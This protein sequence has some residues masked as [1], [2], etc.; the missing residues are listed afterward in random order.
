MKTATLII[1]SNHPIPLLKIWAVF[2][3]AWLSVDYRYMHDARPHAYFCLNFFYHLRSDEAF[4][5][6]ILAF[7]AEACS[8][9][10]RVCTRSLQYCKATNRLGS[11]DRQLV[12]R[13]QTHGQGHIACRSVFVFVVEGRM[14]FSRCT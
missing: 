7:H 1:V 4:R 3:R 5:L 9:Y 6:C 2:I 13:R 12:S 10:I 8:L 11:D 14:E